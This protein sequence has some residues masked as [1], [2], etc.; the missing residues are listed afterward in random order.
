MT[1]PGPRLPVTK[2]KT[3]FDRGA[4]LGR[5]LIRWH[6]YGERFRAK[7]DN[8]KLAGSAKVTVSIPTAPERY[9]EKH[10]YD[11]TKQVL[12]VGD[13]EGLDAHTV[14]PLGQFAKRRVAPKAHVLD[15]GAHTPVEVALGFGVGTPKEFAARRAVEIRPAAR[16]DERP[17]AHRRV[18]AFPG[19][20][21]T[22]SAARR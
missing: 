10:K 7:D 17:R 4:A 20:G 5:E 6:T 13:G 14:E 11:E 18:F 19:F 12:R 3:L 9:P 21:R 22:R 8:F 1:L 2:D 15:Q 16:R